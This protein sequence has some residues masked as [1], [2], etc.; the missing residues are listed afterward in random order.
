MFIFI[1][2]LLAHFIGDYP[3]QLNKIYALKFK[4]LKGVIPHAL[5]VLICLI[6]L[7]WP[8]LY[9]PGLWGFIFF[10]GITHLFQDW[11]K[12]KWKRIKE[13]NYFWFY[14]LDQI[15]HIAV[16]MAV[17]LTGL[18]NLQPPKDTASFFAP[19]YNNNAALI[20]LIAIIIA[21]YNGTYMISNFEKTFFGISYLYTPFEKWYGM[22]ER[23]ILVSI[24]VLGGFFFLLILLVFLMRPLIFALGKSRLNINRHF[25][26]V[27]EMTSS[28]TI[29]MVTGIPL[30][31][32]IQRLI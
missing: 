27:L 21:T 22:L 1:R 5:L 23:A 12:V 30:Y 7:S 9:L 17:F 24:F 13:G 6:I 2:L 16:I 11:I 29:A 4:G 10:I 3:L 14:L 20:F 28:W 31:A 19:F 8:Y 26:S 25:I 18:K 15:L 32:I